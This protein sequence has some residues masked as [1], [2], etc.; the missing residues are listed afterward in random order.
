MHCFAQ[1]TPSVT[2]NPLSNPQVVDIL[3]GVFGLVIPEI[4]LLGSAC[5]LFVAGLFFS[6]RTFAL[7]LALAGLCGAA[8][9][10]Y[11][12]STADAAAYNNFDLSRMLISPVDSGP[13]AAFV[14]WFVLGL[15]LLFL[16]VSTKEIHRETAADYYGCLLVL[17][18]GASMVAR[19]NDLI[20]LFLALELISIPTYVLLYLPSHTKTAQEATAK[21]FMLSVLS[22]GITLFGFSYLYGVTGTTNIPTIV[23][24]LVQAHASESSPLAVLAMVLVVAGIG[25]RITAVPFHYYAP[26]VYQGG[27]LGVISQLAVIPKVAGFIALAR[28]LG[29][30]SPPLENQAFP[31]STQ[32]PLLLWLLAAITMTVG[33]VFALLQDNLK[34]LLAYSGIAHGGYMLLGLVSTSAYAP[35]ELRLA[36]AYVSGIDAILF[37]L[38]AYALMTIGAFAIIIYLQSADQP[39]ESVDD[40][41]GAG[42]THP[43]AAAAL[44]VALL[45]LIGLPLTAGFSGKL[46]LFLSAFA[47][48]PIG[49]L[50]IMYKLL[51]LIA[52]INAAIAAVYYLRVLGVI[53][54]RSPLRPA[55]KTSGVGPLA[56]AIV[57][58]LGTLAI[59]IYPKPLAEATRTAAPSIK[60]VADTS[61]AQATPK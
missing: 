35:A 2:P 34:R 10:A 38:V 17:L 28:I 32:I 49:G 20:S 56:A 6:S 30:L 13:A 19:A 50:G 11:L 27:P 21:Y 60:Q 31:T 52:A 22:S 58:A 18:T 39:V 8:I 29:M 16:M 14:R 12:T 15:G 44:T 46:L 57:C 25:F 42:Q 1:A 51:A 3:T 4:I 5:V 53:Y 24:T 37:Y 23:E 45:S 55:S 26:D 48:P 59:G 54:L 7:L 36:P 41:A 61:V 47:A 43:V 40:L 33:N 9:A